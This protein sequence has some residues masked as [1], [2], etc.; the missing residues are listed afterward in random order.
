MLQR[1]HVVPIMALSL[2]DLMSSFSLE[3]T[4]SMPVV[5]LSGEILPVRIRLS[6]PIALF[7]KQFS[8]QYRFNPYCVDRFRFY[9]HL[10]ELDEDAPLSAWRSIHLAGG[11]WRDLRECPSRLFLVIA[12]DSEEERS[13]KLS[14]IRTILSQRG[15][16]Y[17][18]DDNVLYSEY[19][20]WWLHAQPSHEIQNRYQFL[21]AFVEGLLS[22]TSNETNTNEMIM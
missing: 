6:D 19:L 13:A 10:E 12:D 22:V 20:S 9:T 18:Y 11:R 16:F 2:H 7:P 3:E 14:L 17:P 15:Q 8:D 21:S 5:L 1:P 4:V